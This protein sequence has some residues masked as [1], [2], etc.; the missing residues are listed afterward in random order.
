[1]IRLFR[2]YISRAYLLLLMMDLAVCVLS[3]WAGV[4]IRFQGFDLPED[5]PLSSLV[6]TSVLFALVM[7]LCLTA[8]GLYQRRF[9]EG[10]SGLV[11]RSIGGLVLGVM[12]MSLLFYAFP[13]LFLGRGAFGYSVAIALIG[14]LLMRKIFEK[15]VDRDSQK[16]RILVLG[17]GKNA[18][19]ISQ[20]GEDPGF[21]VVNY[22]PLQG[23]Y[24]NVVD[25]DKIVH[26]NMPLVEYAILKDVDEI[27]VAVDDRRRGLPVDEILDCKMNGFGV[28][29]LLTFFEKEAGRI[30]LSILHP[31]WMVFSDGFKMQG[32]HSK[33]VFDLLVSTV[34]LL[35]VWP[36]MLLVTLAI[37]IESLGC[38]PILYRQVR[39]GQN[40][41]VFNVLKFRSMRV[42]AEKDGVA[43]WA[44][45]NDTRITKVGAFIRK[46]RM[47]ELPQIFN[48]LKGDMSFVGP[49][50]ERP[51]FVEKLAAEIPY[52]AERHRVKPGITGWAQLR[53]PYGSSQQDAIEKLQ[54][55]LYY[56]KNYSLFLDLM[57]IVQTLEIVIWGK[58]Q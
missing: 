30:K 32:R 43:R 55:D 21:I 44:Q 50:P 14:A 34:L 46:T 13:A 36:I 12:I 40:W 39:V 16:R 33:R 19:Q 26:L 18:S 58:G 52:Y 37:L 27:V 53:Y 54:Y 45:K 9:S 7:V 10:D 6:I 8:M 47:D 41:R 28:V 20:L 17:A 48:V 4:Y 29:D 57:I 15:I 5:T 23:Q 35:V 38:G 31:S 3:V 25:K 56:V 49:R 1:M 42:D 11:V 22:V 51:E 24:N 2:H